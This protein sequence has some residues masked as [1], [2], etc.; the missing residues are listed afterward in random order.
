MIKT[1]VAAVAA[2]AALTLAGCM[3]TSEQMARQAAEDYA[4]CQRSRA[5]IN[6][7]MA[8]IR[9]NRANQAMVAAAIAGS[10][11]P[12]I[13]QP[14]FPSTITVQP[15]NMARPGGCAAGYRC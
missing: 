14:S 7:C 11:D 1:I 3:Q 2:V 5:P 4:A 15:S 13:Y 12:P 8:S 10:P 6:E 9:Q